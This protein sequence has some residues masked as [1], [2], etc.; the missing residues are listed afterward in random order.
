MELVKKEIKD[1]G[2]QRQVL[3]ALPYSVVGGACEGSFSQAMAGSSY[4]TALN[5]IVPAGHQLKILFLR[6]C[7]QEQSGARF[8]IYQTNPTALGQ[9]GAIEAYPVVGSVPSGARDYM[10]LEAPGEEVLRGSLVDPVH[11]LEGSIDF[12][13]LAQYPGATTPGVATGARYNLV[14]WGVEKIPEQ[15]TT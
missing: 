5:H 3:E 7:T 9:T 14:W 2:L 6:I 15:E 12:R 8:E 4:L 11:V 10:L 1:L 13:I